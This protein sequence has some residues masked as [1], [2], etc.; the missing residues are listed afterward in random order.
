MLDKTYDDIFEKLPEG[1]SFSNSLKIAWEEKDIFS[2]SIL[3]SCLEDNIII[4]MS[5]LVLANKLGEDI[6]A[7][8]LIYSLY[9]K[10]TN[11]LDFFVIDEVLAYLEDI[12]ADASDYEIFKLY[13]SIMK[14]YKIY[15]YLV[16]K[17]EEETGDLFVSNDILNH[18]IFKLAIS[19]SEKI[20]F[21]T[22]DVFKTFISDTAHIFKTLNI[23]EEEIFLLNKHIF[24]ADSYAYTLKAFL[25]A[26][27]NA[28]EDA[29][30][31][32]T[33]NFAQ[34]SLMSILAYA[35]ENKYK[36]QAFLIITEMFSETEAVELSILNS[37]FFKFFETFFK[38]ISSYQ[39]EFV[40]YVSLFDSS[41][42][43]KSDKKKC[44]YISYLIGNINLSL[45]DIY[46]DFE[47]YFPVSEKE[48][49]EIIQILVNLVDDESVYNN[50]SADVNFLEIIRKNIKIEKR[51]KV[52]SD[53]IK[54]VI[55]E[56]DS[57]VLILQIIL[58]VFRNKYDF[59]D[60]LLNKINYK[61]DEE[62]LAAADSIR[63]K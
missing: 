60:E 37:L 47:I 51:F 38:Q 12:K 63:L 52:I 32:I 22:Y 23:P 44:F 9:F 41:K 16:L 7:Q 40:D 4:K 50:E 26:M 10:F 20:N 55:D 21:I 2:Y 43:L 36:R 57:S 19:E 11:L 45:K 17:I 39:S 46:S 59:I 42:I 28:D 29:L 49:K 61:F 27:L 18:K 14:D 3:S 24:V 8:E 48:F 56:F 58:L 6:K 31:E 13:L 5:E 34:L 54:D 25:Y 62:I 33:D 53:S 35:S 15:E 1:Y 30:M